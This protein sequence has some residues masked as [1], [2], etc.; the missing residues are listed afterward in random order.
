MTVGKNLKKIWKKKEKKESENV[1][2]KSKKEMKKKKM[3]DNTIA[4]I[5]VTFEFGTD[6]C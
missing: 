2:E 3:K 6:A 1:V 4:F 5:S